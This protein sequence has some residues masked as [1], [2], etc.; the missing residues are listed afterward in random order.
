MVNHYLTKSISRRVCRRAAREM[1]TLPLVNL[2]EEEAQRVDNQWKGFAG[3]YTPLFHRLYKTFQ[4]FDERWVSEEVYAPAILRALNPRHEALTLSHKALLPL[5][6]SAIPQPR[7]IVLYHDGKFLSPTFER[8]TRQDVEASLLSA[9]SFIIKPTHNTSRGHGIKRVENPT[10][11]TV[12]QLMKEY[13]HGFIAQEVIRQS[14]QTAQFNPDSVNTFRITTLF[15]NGRAS[16]CNILFRCGQG[17]TCVDNGGAGGLMVGVDEQG[18]FMPYA[19]DK[20]YQ[21]HTESR[22]GVKFEGVVIPQLSAT[23]AQALEW[24]RQYMPLCGIVGWDIAL[25]E[26]NEPLMVEM[27][28]R[29]PGIVF[30]QI[31]T[32]KP[33]FG[34]RTDEVIEYAKSHKPSLGMLVAERYNL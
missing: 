13:K 27:N 31:C 14:A 15:L 12:R 9:A 5:R 23:V 34:E 33:F 22:N 3:E 7:F 24:H 2:T 20:Y 6:F 1:A 18:R 28:L 16:L 8:S 21:R 30:E 11:E 19:F 10:R 32:D 26:N 4:R 29:F 25:N 17:N